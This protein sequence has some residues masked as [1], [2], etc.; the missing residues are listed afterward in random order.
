MKPL[1]PVEPMT[2]QCVETRL[3][4]DYYV[5][6]GGNSYSVDPL[7]IGSR[8]SVVMDLTHV[9]IVLAGNVITTHQ[10]CWA[11]NRNITDPAHQSIAQRLRHRARDAPTPR[12]D[13]ENV[14]LRFMTNY[15][16]LR[17]LNEHQ[18]RRFLR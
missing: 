2:G 4:R 9:R 3:G 13:V 15:W 16:K 12:T 7:H 6:I 18:G 5:T 17:P 10:R 8:I 11:K 1:P 14:I